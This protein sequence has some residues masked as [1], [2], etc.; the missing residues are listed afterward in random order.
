MD[1]HMGNGGYYKFCYSDILSISLQVFTWI[2][3]P[4]IVSSD[5]ETAIHK[6]LNSMLTYGSRA[7][8]VCES[9]NNSIA[10]FGGHNHTGL[11]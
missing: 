6:A 7:N 9:W 10:H 5:F 4:S 1:I 3:Y 11:W 8:N 2:V